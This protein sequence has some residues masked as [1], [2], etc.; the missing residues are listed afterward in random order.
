MT[1]LDALIDELR[2]AR[3]P[4]RSTDLASRIG[5]SESALGGMITVL[6]GKGVLASPTDT[7]TGETVACSGAACGKTCV[8]L[9]ACPFIVDIPTTY[10]L[11]ITPPRG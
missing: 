8:G 9:E 5:V 4:I 6:T 1:V 11:V 2:A 10:S 3:G 7:A